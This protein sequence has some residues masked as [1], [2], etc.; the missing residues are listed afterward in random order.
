MKKSQQQQTKFRT[1]P[2]SEIPGFGEVLTGKKT[3]KQAASEQFSNDL[4]E[5]F[6]SIPGVKEIFS[7]GPLNQ[8]QDNAPDCT[9]CDSY[10]FKLH[11]IRSSAYRC[12]VLTVL[13]ADLIAKEADNGRITSV[14]AEIEN[15]SREMQLICGTAY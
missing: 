10:L 6:S 8:Q 15:Q 1:V 14:L 11:Q 12:E 5:F 3:A 9:E 13:V 7:K 4:G 2:L